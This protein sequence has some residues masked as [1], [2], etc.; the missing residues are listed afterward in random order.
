MNHQPLPPFPPPR[1]PDPDRTAKVA[2]TVLLSV[3]AAALLVGV[4]LLLRH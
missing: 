4:F 1:P 2:T 3:F